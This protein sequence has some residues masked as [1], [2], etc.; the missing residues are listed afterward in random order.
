MQQAIEYYN[1]HLSISKALGDEV[2]ERRA[3]SDLGN[4]YES[5]GDFKRASEYRNRDLS[6]AKELEDKAGEG[7]AYGNLGKAFRYLGDFKQA[8]E[9]HKHYLVI[10]KELGDKAGEGTAWYSLGRDFEYYGSSVKLYSDVRALLKCED[11]W[12][13]AFRNAYQYAYTAFWKIV[14]NV[15]KTEEALCVAQQGRA[16]SLVDLVKLKYN[17]EILASEAFAT[18]ETVFDIL[19]DICTKQFS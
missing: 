6:I 10:A 14:L 15:Q 17:P 8:I 19:T 5:L 4:A 9:Y 18:K 1:Q 12:K 7:L 2:G 13:I 16:Q 3:Y 11:M